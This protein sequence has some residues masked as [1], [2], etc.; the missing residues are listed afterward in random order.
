MMEE[1][2]KLSKKVVD[3]ESSLK[4]VRGQLSSTEADRD[5]LTT[6][7]AAEEAALAEARK[8][9]AKAERDVAAAAEQAKADLEA[10][11]EHFEGL[12]QKAKA[13]QVDAEERAREAAAQGLARKLKEAEGKAE[14]LTESCFE[15]R[16]AL[17][18]QRQ[19]ADLREEMLK[20]GKGVYALHATLFCNNNTPR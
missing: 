15:L 9:K 1:G 10:Q 2:E 17:D 20:V 5:K 18:R 6:R 12:L 16:D 11:R 14:A 13:D 8:A 7:L 4:R 3:L 19:A